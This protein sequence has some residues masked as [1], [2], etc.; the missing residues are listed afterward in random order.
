MAAASSPAPPPPSSPPPGIENVA[1]RGS[2]VSPSS[3]GIES[4]PPMGGESSVGRRRLTG[5]RLQGLPGGHN[6]L[7]AQEQGLSVS[8]GVRARLARV[9]GGEHPPGQPP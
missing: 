6:G 5:Y 1:R 3:G 2:S 7:V 9:N 4:S 8:P